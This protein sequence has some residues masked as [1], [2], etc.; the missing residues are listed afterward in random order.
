MSI[1]IQTYVKIS[2]KIDVNI[3]MGGVGKHTHRNMDR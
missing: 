2:M 1:Q 3:D